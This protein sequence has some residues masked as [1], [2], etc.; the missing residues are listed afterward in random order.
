MAS[1]WVATS[2]TEDRGLLNSAYA[3]A[4][5]CNRIQI[6]ARHEFEPGTFTLSAPQPT[7]RVTG[8]RQGTSRQRVAKGVTGGK[9]R[10]AYHVVKNVR[11]GPA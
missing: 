7:K 10:A 3:R 5:L 11:T 1:A 4:H 2:F 9:K 8:K 6:G